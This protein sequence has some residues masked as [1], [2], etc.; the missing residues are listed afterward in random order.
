MAEL[1]EDA[2]FLKERNVP[3]LIN[4][5][6]CHVLM[7]R[8]D[9]VVG[10]MLDYLTTVE[11]AK[12]MG[13]EGGARRQSK[14]GGEEEELG[15]GL[16]DLSE[17]KGDLNAEVR[18]RLKA[19]VTKL[20]ISKNT[21]TELPQALLNNTDVTELSVE[22]NQLGSLDGILTMSNLVYL[23]ISDN[24]KFK[25]LPEGF[26][27][28]LPHLRK[29][30]AYKCGF[31]GQMS[32]E[33]EKCSKIT[34]VNFYNNSILKPPNCGG[35]TELIELNFSSNKI[36]AI[37]EGSFENL[38]KLRRL[39]FFWNRLLKIPP[40]TPLVALKELQLNGNQL[41]EMPVLG[42][43]KDLE[44]INLSE[45]KITT[46]NETLFVQEG[47][48]S[49][50]AGK[51]LLTDASI[52]RGWPALVNL[53]KIQMPDNQLTAIPDQFLDLPNL[54]VLE[55]NSNQIKSLPEDIDRLENK[56]VPL[57]HLFLA[58][59]LFTTLPVA[60]GSLTSLKRIA[61]RGCP[62]DLSNEA[63]KTTYEKLEQII[64]SKGIDGKFLDSKRSGLPPRKAGPATLGADA[65]GGGG[66]GGDP[67]VKKARKSG[68]AMPQQSKGSS[69]GVTL[70]IG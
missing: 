6:M 36:M 65:L 19:G 49:F 50:A 26:S 44:E 17:F 1:D 61:F 33:I 16:E 41:P 5:L 22:E 4:E 10:C 9:D 35:L 3:G 42:V 29:I 27:S 58:E 64:K 12:Y 7:T 21:L 39:A 51:N 2:S 66:G 8:P 57:N 47:L 24:P 14:G 46:L 38:Q 18:K 15:E 31:S 20:N 56:A 52:L 23:N 34:H 53:K 40:L 55:L 30:D 62:L 45:N 48:E 11:R 60:M 70:S 32:A 69:D 68:D 59:N 54:V 67:E 43:H 28:K 13:G 25:D 63:T 37:P